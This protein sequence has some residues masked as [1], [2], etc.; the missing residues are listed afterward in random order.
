[1]LFKNVDGRKL[2]KE[3][4]WEVIYGMEEEL[5]KIAGEQELEEF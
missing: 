4:R 2:K 1:L 5:G 3:K